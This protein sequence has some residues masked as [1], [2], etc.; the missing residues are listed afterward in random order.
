MSLLDLVVVLE[1]TTLLDGIQYHRHVHEK[2]L[3]GPILMP[4]REVECGVLLQQSLDSE[5]SQLHN[6]FLDLVFLRNVGIG[7]G[8]CSLVR[9]HSC[10]LSLSGT[11]FARL[12]VRRPCS[13]DGVETMSFLK[14]ERGAS[15][16]KH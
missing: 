4:N 5:V 10:G 2:G 13:S 16:T 11:D 6:F 3:L 15:L 9:S 1:V 14:E 8:S 12:I 7:G